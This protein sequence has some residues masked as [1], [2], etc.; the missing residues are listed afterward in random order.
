MPNVSDK[1]KRQRASRMSPEERKAELLTH[2]IAVCAQ[3][4]ISN[5]GHTEIAAL[6]GVSIPTVFRY[7]PT[8]A[9][10]DH[11]VLKEV[12][13]FLIGEIVNPH[14]KEK[15]PANESILNVL[16]AFTTAIDENPFYI[17]IWLEWSASVRD[18]VWNMYLEFYEAAIKG[19]AYIVKR[20][21]REG[22]IRKNLNSNDAARII[23]GFAHIIAHMK[24]AGNSRSTIEHTLDSLVTGYLDI[25]EK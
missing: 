7:F 8:K 13:R 1:P 23:V 20:G 17:R 14:L 19:T 25:P 4:G 10:L 2:A 11:D 6:A 15:C 21:Q 16:R 5:S 9:E 12:H 3:R 18:G 22:V 24:F